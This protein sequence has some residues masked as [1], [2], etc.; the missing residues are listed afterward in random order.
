M[1]RNVA[2]RTDHLRYIQSR[3]RKLGLTGTWPISGNSGSHSEGHARRLPHAQAGRTIP[4]TVRR[5]RRAR[6]IHA[7]SVLELL[8]GAQPRNSGPPAV[9]DC[10]RTAWAIGDVRDDIMTAE[11]TKVPPIL[12]TW[13]SPQYPRGRH[14]RRQALRTSD[15]PALGT[16]T[17]AATVNSVGSS[18]IHEP[19]KIAPRWR[20]TLITTRPRCGQVAESVHFGH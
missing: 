2:Q 4:E 12:A 6:V 10:S 17:T 16:T 14:D 1:F 19:C 13:S 18:D 7:T 5:D 9:E 8:P 11:Y 20:R 3:S 15:R